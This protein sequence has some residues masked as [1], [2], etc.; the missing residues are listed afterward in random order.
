M[1]KASDRKG[2]KKNREEH[3]EKRK[4]PLAT[5]DIGDEAAVETVFLERN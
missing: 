3:K 5:V 2:K 4:D 1:G